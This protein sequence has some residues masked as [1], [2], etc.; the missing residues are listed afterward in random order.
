MN[1]PVL[2]Q[3]FGEIQLMASAERAIYLQLA[4]ALQLLIKNGRLAAGQKL[5]G[6]RE[7]AAWLRLNR[8]TVNKAYEDLQMQGWLES[9]AGRG[10]FVS[11]RLP[12]LHPTS[13]HPVLVNSSR[14]T[15][16]FALTEKP[17]LENAPVY[18]NTRLHLDDGF[19]DPAM[20]PLA[21]LYRAYRS[22][23]TRTSA[24]YTR[25]GSYSEPS[26]PD[27]YKAALSAH[28]NETRGLKTT[29][30]NILSVRGT[31]MGVHLVCSGLVQPG[32]VVVSAIPGWRRAEQNFVHAGARHMGIPAD[33]Y[34]LVTEELE[35]ICRS[36]RVRMVYVTSHHHYPTT[37]SLRIDRRLALLQLA[38]QYGFIV[39]EDDYDYDFHYKHRPLQP[40]ASADENGMVIYCGSFSKS[41]SPAFRMGYLV[42][43]ENVVEH[44]ARVRLLL[45][46]QGDHILD[47]AMAELLNTGTV[48]RYLRKAA[49][50]YKERRDFFCE[51]LAAELSHAVQFMVPEGGMT[52]WAR[53]DKSIDL[54]L[55]A[56]RALQKG[57]FMSDGKA[58]NYPGLSPNA[59]RLGFASSAIPQLEESIFLLK[60]LL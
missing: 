38:Q 5:P 32:D 24:L 12:T 10:T 37:V 27:Y 35:K 15:A 52:V 48:Q 58:H 34:G 18:P 55:L 41:F 20:A 46:R 2:G 47:N 49:A 53:F 28:L 43:S 25:F 54:P 60:A 13:L 44:L 11:A 22:Q 42:A 26:G 3:I 31:V 56:K 40:L 30:A 59:A 23:L 6:T 36:T 33:E 45:D 39:F 21:E 7:A 29:P 8:I 57:L 16:G 51:G 17:W 1:S 4:D 9:T 50:T 14:Q 19:P